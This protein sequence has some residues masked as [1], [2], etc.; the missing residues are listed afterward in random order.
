MKLSPVLGYIRTSREEKTII[1]EKDLIIKQQKE[2]IKK[3][4]NDIKNLSSESTN[5]TFQ[6]KIAHYE[7]QHQ[8]HKTTISLLR[9]LVIKQSAEIRKGKKK[10]SY[11]IDKSDPFF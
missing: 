5:T 7:N 4:Q 6:N 3:L 11:H 2:Q 8:I 10:K 1:E 9:D